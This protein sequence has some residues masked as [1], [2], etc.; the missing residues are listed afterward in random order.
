MEA[1]GELNEEAMLTY[2][3]D[4]FADTP[5]MIS[6]VEESFRICFHTTESI[7]KFNFPGYDC[8]LENALIMDCLYLRIFM[9]CAETSWS[10]NEICNDAREYTDKCYP[11]YLYN[12]QE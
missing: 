1:N 12:E 8:P 11:K 4:V 7:R 5:D 2:V 10:N 6:I 3:N 9:F